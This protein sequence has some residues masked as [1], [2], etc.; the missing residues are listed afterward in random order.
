MTQSSRAH[1]GI[2][3]L[4]TF[5]TTSHQAHDVFIQFALVSQ[6]K[7]WIH[8]QKPCVGSAVQDVLQD[9]LTAMPHGGH[10]ATSTN[11]QKDHVQLRTNPT[12][13]LREL[14]HLL[15]PGLK[16]LLLSIIVLP[17]VITKHQYGWPRRSTAARAHR[18]VGCEATAGRPRRA[19]VRNLAAHVAQREAAS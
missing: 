2:H 1:V 10:I 5:Q 8:P 15:C 17:A 18:V 14:T 7:V 13:L 3:H 19:L 6:W 4:Q 12:S 11:L 16:A 9:P